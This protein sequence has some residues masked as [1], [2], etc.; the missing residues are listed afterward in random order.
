MKFIII[1]I[2]VFVYTTAG[3]SQVG[4]HLKPVYDYLHTSGKEPSEYIT[5]KFSHHDVVFLGED[6]AIRENLVFVASL[7]PKLYAIG[8]RNIGM[9]FGASEDQIRLDSL[10]SADRYDEQTARDIMFDYNVGWAYREYT[11]LY[12]EVWK[13][14]THLSPGSKFFRICNMSYRFDWRSFDGHRT[15]ATMEKI[16][17]KGP[18]DMYR[19]GILEKEILEKGEKILVLTGTPH[20]FTKYKSPGFGGESKDAYQE[21]DLGNRLYKKYPERTFSVILH[22]PFWCQDIKK[23]GILSP[24]NGAIEQ[25]MNMLD[26]KPLGFDLGA[27]P[28]GMLPDTSSYASGYNDFHIGQLFDGYIFLKPIDK[29]SGCTIDTLFFKGKTWENVQRQIPDPDWHKSPQSFSEYWVQ[30]KNYVD[31]H[32]RYNLSGQ[33]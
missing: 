4:Q 11:D 30:I 19:T 21:A 16:F 18:I 20:A 17:M 8:V 10:V 32:A 24:A 27:T 13:F 9:E 5:E 15:R 3:Q 33:K 6:H 25:I 1:F 22:Q 23:P 29:L 12:R 28:P 2:S 31:M 14:N 7:I 26:D